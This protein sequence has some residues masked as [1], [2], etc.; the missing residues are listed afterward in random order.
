MV[1]LGR[2][3]FPPL[4]LH[5]IP[6]SS[7]CATTG[8]KACHSFDSNARF[9]R[10]FHPRFGLIMAVF[11]SAE[12]SAGSEVLV[13]YRYP[14]GTAPPWYRQQWHDHLR[15]RHGWGAEDIERFGYRVHE[16]PASLETVTARIRAEKAAAG[17]N[18]N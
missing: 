1:G 12:V 15:R 11:A 13:N 10:F 9:G 7:Y 8:H 4:I 5:S 18:G 3:F 6:F 14:I 17:K 2:I 16:V